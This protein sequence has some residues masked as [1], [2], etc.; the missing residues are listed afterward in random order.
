MDFDIIMFLID[1]NMACVI[2]HEPG[3]KSRLC[4]PR[5]DVVYLRLHTGIQFVVANASGSVSRI[6]DAD[7]VHW[8]IGH[9]LK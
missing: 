9:S 5:P 3:S 7:G 6:S 1:W 4:R 2:S 8:N